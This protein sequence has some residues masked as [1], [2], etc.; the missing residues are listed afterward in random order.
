MHERINSFDQFYYT[1]EFFM[2]WRFPQ[3]GK[4]VSLV[5]GIVNSV[6]SISSNNEILKDF[7]LKQ[8]K[9][10]KLF[11]RIGNSFVRF[12]QNDEILREV[13]TFKKYKLAIFSPIK[14][15]GPKLGL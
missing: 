4:S 12:H 10:Q 7:S 11:E 3:T 5:E 15:I 14:S 2:S 6:R 13:R 9:L 1:T 8:G